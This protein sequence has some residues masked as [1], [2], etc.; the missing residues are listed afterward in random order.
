MIL[1]INQILKIPQLRQ[2]NNVV[3][4]SIIVVVPGTGS[5][6]LV[7]LVPW[8]WYYQVLVPGTWYQKYYVLALSTRS[9]F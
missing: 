9:D 5:T 2:A 8:Y 3:I 7:V 4:C 6:Y 1:V